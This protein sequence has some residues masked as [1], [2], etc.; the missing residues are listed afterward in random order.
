[1]RRKRPAKSS[2]STFACIDRKPQDFVR[3]SRRL[4]KALFLFLTFLGS[5]II[6]ILT[7]NWFESH[8]AFTVRIRERGLHPRFRVQLAGALPG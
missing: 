4:G 2:L 7:Y 6:S 5:I 8:G 3:T 1:M